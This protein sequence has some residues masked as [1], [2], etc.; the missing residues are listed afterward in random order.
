MIYK[1]IVGSEESENFK[2]E[3]LIDSEDTFLR[4]RNVILDAAGYN[5]DQ[6]DSFIICDEDWNKEKEVTYMEMDS[7]S[8]EDIWIMEDTTLAELIE[9]EGQRMKFVFDY[10]TDRYF[11]LRLKETQPGKSLHDPLCQRKEGKA[12]KESI[13]LDTVMPVIP[14]VESMQIEELDADFFGDEEFNDD[15]L[16]DFDEISRDDL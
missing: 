13:D 5:K 6:L 1:F 14:K 16:D 10:M 9:E 7:D 4:L 3:I 8:D 12:P 15:E 11:Y 2:L